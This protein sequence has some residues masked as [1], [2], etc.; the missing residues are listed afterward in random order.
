MDGKEIPA[1]MQNF[2]GV[3]YM[4]I[5]GDEKTGFRTVMSPG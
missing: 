4:L 3:E 5:L 1:L 2:P